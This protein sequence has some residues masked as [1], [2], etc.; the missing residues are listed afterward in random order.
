MKN[1]MKVNEN[2]ECKLLM[3]KA[4]ALW[5]RRRRRSLRRAGGVKYIGKDAT[6]IVNPETGKI[7]TVYPTST[8]RANSILKTQKR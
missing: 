1:K 7:I 5:L 8:Q 3:N 6:V 4:G 2:I